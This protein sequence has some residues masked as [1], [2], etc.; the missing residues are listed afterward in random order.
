MGDRVT[1]GIVGCGII[2][3]NHARAIEASPDAD[4]LAVADV[5]SE[6]ARAFAEA[7]GRPQAYPDYRRLLERD[8]I[9]VVCVTVPSGLHAEVAMAAMRAGKHV[10]CEKP[11]EIRR[12]RLNQMIAVSET[13]GRQLG[14]VYQRRTT[15]VA[16][17]A[18]AAV[19]AGDLGRLVLGDALLKYHRSA[20]YYRGADWRATWALDGGG[21]LMNQGVH[22]VDLLQ[23]LMG[24]IRRVSARTATLVHAIEVEDTAVAYL[25]FAS[26]ALGV[27]TAATSIYPEQPTRLSVH[28]SQGSLVFSDRGVEEWTVRGE[29]VA[30]RMGDVAGLDFAHG[31]RPFI[32]NMVAVVRDGAQ[33]LV[34][35]REGRKAV[36]VILAIYE[37]SR[38]GMPVVVTHG[39]DGASEETSRS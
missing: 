37:S 5:V 1:F 29:D 13:T 8:D 24:D 26:G 25:E 11:L 20:D 14:V 3:E 6:R 33:P 28:G 30:P 19:D 23:W 39:D 18:K 34:P 27:I 17:A 36:D 9:A 15:P 2:A 35:A 12:D 32:D 22:G 31:H 16:K 4:L 38:R 7:H 10:L 21:A